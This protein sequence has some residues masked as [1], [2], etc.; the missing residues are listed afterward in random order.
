MPQAPPGENIYGPGQGPQAQPQPQAQVP[1]PTPQPQPVVAAPTPEP[2]NLPPPVP[3]QVVYRNGLLS[4]EALN[5]TLGAILTAIRNKT[6]IQFEGLEG[7]ATER[8]VLSIGPAT[9]GEVLATILGGSGYDYVAIDRSDSPGIVQRVLMTPR[10][11]STAT[12]AGGQPSVS[13]TT[14]FDEGDEADD[15]DPDAMRNPQDM[16][17]RPPVLQAQPQPPQNIPQPQVNPPTVNPQV[18]PQAQVNPQTGQAPPNPEQLLE[19]LK[20]MQEQRLQQNP[21]DAPHKQPPQ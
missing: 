21:P 2:A 4:V 19:E 6:G 3:P 12:A 1:P 13:P 20:R 8:V 11:G 14:A 18:N 16:P 15:A 9:E 7:G 10:G 5:C 17:A